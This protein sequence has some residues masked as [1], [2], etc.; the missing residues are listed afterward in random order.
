MN[1]QPHQ[2]V[3]VSY[4][5]TEYKQHPTVQFALEFFYTNQLPCI[6]FDN[7]KDTWIDVLHNTLDPPPRI[8]NQRN[9]EKDTREYIL[10]GHRKHE[11]LERA[12]QENPEITHF[13]WIDI[14][15]FY[16]LWR[17]NICFVGE[18]LKWMCKSIPSWSSNMLAFP[19]CWA[20]ES[21]GTIA[22]LSDSVCWRFCGGIFMG[23]RNSL[24]EWLKLYKFYMTNMLCEESVLTW[25]FN[26]WALVEQNLPPNKLT[27]Y[28]ANNDETVLYIPPDLYA[29]KLRVSQQIHLHKHLPQLEGFHSTSVSHIFYEGEH[30]TNTR[31]VSYSILPNGYYTFSRLLGM[32]HNY[33]YNKNVLSKLS[34]PNRYLPESS[35][36][37]S[38]TA[39]QP[40]QLPETVSTISDGLEDLRLFVSWNGDVKYIA[41]TCG[42][43][44]TGTPSMI[45]GEYSLRDS[46]I[47]SGHVVHPPTPTRCEKN[48]IPIQ[49]YMEDLFLYRW[50]PTLQYGA[51]RDNTLEICREYPMTNPIF[52]NVRGSTVFI[53][54]VEGKYLLGVVHFSVETTPRHYYH[55]LVRLRPSSLELDSYT[56]PFIFGDAHGIEFC[57]GMW[58][59]NTDTKCEYKFWVSFHDRDPTLLT[60]DSTSF[61]WITK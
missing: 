5:P 4:V 50:W 10:S 54:D 61:L 44:L 1:Q 29:P 56:T 15:I 57:I 45:V 31:Y 22:N 53:P 12:I 20:K 51:I 30:W 25:D 2:L 41:T 21:V 28:Y 24:T 26:I 40:L 59:E 35:R 23:D 14:N 17:K 18:Y 39:L 60:V 7:G 13:M 16:D 27:W 33:I 49:G 46:A 58:I 3:F 38:E 32:R 55:M 43:S 8:P 9:F 34:L 6:F 47:V 11:Y 37:V 48:W 36:V 52:R 42:Y 19:G